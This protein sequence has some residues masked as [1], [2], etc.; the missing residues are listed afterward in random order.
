MDNTPVNIPAENISKA[1]KTSEQEGSFTF[2][3]LA[4]VLFLLFFRPAD[5]FTSLKILHLP[6]LC[7]LICFGSHLVSSASRGEPIFRITPITKVLAALS[8]WC[9]ISI[10]FAY[11]QGGAFATFVNDWMKMLVLFLLLVNVILTVKQL[12]I[13]IWICVLCATAVSITAIV[14]FMLHGSLDA[15]GRLTALVNGPY[16]GAN[17]F[18]VTIVLMLPFAMFDA[19][20]HPRIFVRILAFVCCGIFV[21]ANLMTQSRAGIAGMVLVGVLF[22]WQLRKWGKSLTRILV[23]SALLLPVAAVLTPHGVWERFSTIF[24]DYDVSSLS[25]T[26]GLRMAAG[27]QKE[28]LQL[29]YKAV[30]LTLDRPIFGVGMGDFSSASAHTWTSGSGRDW[31]QTHNTYLQISSE[32]GI[33]GLALYITLL[34]VTFKTMRLARDQI[35]EGGPGTKPYMLRLLCDATRVSLI[36]YLLTSAFANVGYQP[37]YFIIAGIGQAIALVALKVTANEPQTVPRPAPAW[38]PEAEANPV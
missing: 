16:A 20:L 4:F 2:G 19:F 9:L 35:P 21:L 17:Y 15:S 18:S 30:T 25:P 13:A 3:V 1:V 24:E 33:P 36:G 38:P 6:L 27:S 7:V 23:V 29:I 22:L 5:L 31:V 8:L 14:G 10:P 32:L 34:V 26:S 28:R 11:W 12:R 37:Y